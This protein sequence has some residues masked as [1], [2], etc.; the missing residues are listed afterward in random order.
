MNYLKISDRYVNMDH[1]KYLQQTPEGI[2]VYFTNDEVFAIT[3]ED[4]KYLVG[5]LDGAHSATINR[6]NL[7]SFEMHERFPDIK[8]K[9]N[10]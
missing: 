2:E 6:M 7:V 10:G 4:A 5:T 8:L 3:G 9:L 1:V